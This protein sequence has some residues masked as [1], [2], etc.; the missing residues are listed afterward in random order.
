MT[1]QQTTS[2]SATRAVVRDLDGEFALVEASQTGCGRC[3][4]PGGCGGLHPGKILCT[5]KPR[6]FRALNTAG[7]RVGDSVSVA[8][9][10]G[11][12]GAAATRAYLLPLVL[13]LAGA[14]AG[15]ALLG[16]AAGLWASVSG[17]LLG[18]GLGWRILASRR[19][20]RKPMLPVIVERNI[21]ADKESS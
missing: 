12:I 15:E 20:T 11:A 13:L 18:L 21:R 4:E 2:F 16:H 7:A 19:L 5:S 9:A 17:A 1:E 14:I 3:S 10:E 6:L 8:V